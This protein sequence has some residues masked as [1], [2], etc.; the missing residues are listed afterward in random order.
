MSDEITL[1]EKISFLKHLFPEDIY[2]IP[3]IAAVLRVHPN[4]VRYWLEVYEVPMFR[5]TATP[6]IM[7][8]SVVDMMLKIDAKTKCDD[9]LIG[10]DSVIASIKKFPKPHKP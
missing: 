6:K 7:Q 1:D 9:R 3:M 5:V 4:T 8:D 2:T 10:L